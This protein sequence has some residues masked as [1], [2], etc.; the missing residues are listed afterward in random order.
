LTAAVHRS[1]KCVLNGVAT[2]LAIPD[3][4]GCETLK[5]SKVASVNQLDLLQTCADALRTHHRHDGLTSRF[6]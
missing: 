6:L 2:R 3:D 5:L 1:G 4:R